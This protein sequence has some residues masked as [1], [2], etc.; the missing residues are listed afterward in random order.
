MK[1]YINLIIMVL[2]FFIIICIF[3]YSSK[4]KKSIIDYKKIVIGFCTDNFVIERWQRDQELF[5]R[6]AKEKGVELIV[7]NANE[8]IENQNEQIYSLIEKKVD[9]IVVIPNK[10]DGI[11]EAVNEAR[12]AGIKV[13]AY[14]RLITDTEIDAYV[15][16]DNFKV[17][18]LQAKALIE[19]VPKGKY[20]IIN[21]SPD[22]NNSLMFNEGYMNVL[23]K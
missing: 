18:E 14:D 4:L 9:V 20:I 2:V 13:I 1:K 3:L 5:I 6:E 22:D 12:K 8:N 10:K 21:G 15:S 19:K 23:N 7:Y 11:I 16:F 17:G